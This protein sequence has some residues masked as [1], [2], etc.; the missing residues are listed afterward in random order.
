MFFLHIQKVKTLPE[1]FI[2]I[3]QKQTAPCLAAEG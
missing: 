1:Y 3:P 2:K